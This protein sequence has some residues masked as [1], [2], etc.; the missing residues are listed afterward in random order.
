MAKTDNM[1]KPGAKANKTDKASKASKTS[2]KKASSKND[3]N[4]D[5]QDE[6]KKARKQQ[7]KQDA[8]LMLKVEDAKKD[9]Q[10]AQQ[11]V[12]KAQEKLNATQAHLH[13]LEEKAD[14]QKVVAL[15]PEGH[16]Q[17]EQS[18]ASNQ[19]MNGT[20]S[21]AS[22]PVDQTTS[23]PPA[24]GRNDLSGQPQTQE[25]QASQAS[26]NTTTDTT[27][28]GNSQEPN[29]AGQTGATENREAIFSQLPPEDTQVESDNASMPILTQ[30]EHAWPPPTTREEVAEAIVEV[31]S[32]ES[33][34]E[35]EQSNQ[36]NTPTEH[37]TSEV[38]E[39]DDTQAMEH[40]GDET[41]Q[42]E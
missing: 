30:D 28:Q 25:T 38:P 33:K 16:T 21:T 22:T 41:H 18:N 24:E 11:K 26:D 29:V 32:N 12:I 6:A 37:A 15:L 4:H 39:N 17:D 19:S 34:Q 40:Y 9:V 42:Q 5:A 23:Q 2:S 13:K 36:S 27:S 7:A 31:V 14:S 20:A 8:K 3:A 35:G 10:K 1:D